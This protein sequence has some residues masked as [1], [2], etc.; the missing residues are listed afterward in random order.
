MKLF[1]YG[2]SYTWANDFIGL[3]LT[4]EGIPWST[5]TEYYDFHD[6]ND[7]WEEDTLT[8]EQPEE[9]DGQDI[10][11]EESGEAEQD[12]AKTGKAEDGLGGEIMSGNEMAAIDNTAPEKTLL[13]A[14]SFFFTLTAKASKLLDGDV[15]TEIPVTR[16]AM[17]TAAI[18]VALSLQKHQQ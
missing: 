6:L 5:L 14:I 3:R 12:L 7:F 1:A 9:S 15:S 11:L 8:E 2:L 18:I 10:M 13:S 4:G 16:M 17:G